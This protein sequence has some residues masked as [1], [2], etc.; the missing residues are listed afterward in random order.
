VSCLLRGR[1][2]RWNP[3]SECLSGSLVPHTHILQINAYYTTRVRIKSREMSQ[4]RPTSHHRTRHLR[5]C[6]RSQFIVAWAS[7]PCGIGR[8]L[9][10]ANSHGQDAHA[11]SHTPSQGW[12][13]DACA[14]L[15]I[16]LIIRERRGRGQFRLANSPCW[17][18]AAASRTFAASRS[19][20]Y[21]PR[22]CWGPSFWR[23]AYHF[24]SRLSQVTPM[25]WDEQPSWGRWLQAFWLWGQLRKQA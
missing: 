6:V 1:L 14:I 25:Y 7:S 5:G 8:M 12:F 11:T 2:V 22:D 16:S 10:A 24:L 20:S 9:H 4:R 18:K 17:A 21:R 13:F 19:S 3:F 23:R 15:D